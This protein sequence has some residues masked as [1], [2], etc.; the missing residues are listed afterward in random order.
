MKTCRLTSAPKENL[1][2]PFNVSFYLLIVV[3]FDAVLDICFDNAPNQQIRQERQRI[4]GRHKHT[5]KVTF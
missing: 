5:I 3:V 4:I 1:G 2:N